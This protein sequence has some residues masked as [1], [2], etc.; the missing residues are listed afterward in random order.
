MDRKH[1]LKIAGLSAAATTI[2]G[3]VACRREIVTGSPAVSL[4]TVR[5]GETTAGRAVYVANGRNRFE[6]EMMIWGVIPL[7]IK[8]S[9]EDTAGNLFVFE[10][11]DMGAGGP[12]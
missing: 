5:G 3:V 12:P 7:Q 2:G 9:T 1:F 8:V 10:H 6:K 4:P 11:A